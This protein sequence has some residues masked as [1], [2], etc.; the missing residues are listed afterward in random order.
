MVVGLNQDDAHNEIKRLKLSSRVNVACVNSPQNVTISGD[1][2]AIEDLHLALESRDVFKRK[3]LT[4]GRA[5]HSH[6]MASL[7]QEY[8]TLI[9]EALKEFEF[10][11]TTQTEIL[12][13][14]SVTAEPLTQADAHYWRAN[15]ESPVLFMQALQALQSRRDFQLIEVGPHSAL[16]LPI[17]ELRKHLGL[18]EADLPYFNALSRGE[19]SA[20]S[21]LRLMGHLFITGV[22]VSFHRINSLDYTS[23]PAEAVGVVLTDLQPY[24][25][26]YDQILWHECRASTEFRNR[27]SPRHELL[28]SMIPG[29]DKLNRSWRNILQVKDVPWLEDHKLGE[30][31]VFPATAY[32]AMAIEALFQSIGR[33]FTEVDSVELRHFH[34]LTALTLST[35]NPGISV[36]LF[37]SLQRQR[38]SATTKSKTW[39][40]FEI[41]SYKDGISTI[42]ATG[43]IRIQG[44]SKEVVQRLCLDEHVMGNTSTQRWYDKFIKE[45]LNFGPA[46]QSIEELQIPRRKRLQQAIA[47]VRF[48]QQGPGAVSK[49]SKYVVHPITMDAMLQTAIIASTSGLIQD[50]RAQIPVMIEHA[51]IKIP[52][53]QAPFQDCS[54]YSAAESSGFSITTVSSELL[55]QKGQLCLQL[56]DVRLVAFAGSDNNESRPQRHPMLRVLWKPDILGFCLPSPQSLYTCLNPSRLQHNDNVIGIGT[57]Y[58]PEL[59]SALDL[60][61]HKNPR[62]RILVLGDQSGFARSCLTIARSKTAFPRYHSFAVGR[63]TD[64]ETYE[65]KTLGKLSSF[66]DN[67]Q[68]TKHKIEAAFDLVAVP[69][70][71]DPIQRVSTAYH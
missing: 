11:A 69:E 44:N 54:V 38:L 7:G 64:S 39:W 32:A 27:K 34:I 58:G 12:F 55:D 3:L 42:H 17:L 24:Q 28:G 50:L 15:L 48:L 62:L 57:Q 23:K 61:C 67:D 9:Y 26:T 36:E 53:V 21:L 4:G 63:L 47:K 68:F 5:Y 16:K 46:F 45:G 37:T 35:Q 30:N 6:H 10:P 2:E 22:D 59:L 56:H 71:D 25:W 41:V 43:T 8:E 29:G 13:I 51:V 33:S 66:N 52:S 14:S 60:I 19:N 20:F 40:S 18:L 31:I 65:V 70:V 49:D 1:A